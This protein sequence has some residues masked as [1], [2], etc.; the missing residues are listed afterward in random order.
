MNNV[1]RNSLPGYSVDF[2]VYSDS[3]DSSITEPPGANNWPEQYETNE[4]FSLKQNCHTGKINDLIV[5]GKKLKN[6]INCLIIQN[7]EKSERL[8]KLEAKIKFLERGQSSIMK[9]VTS[10]FKDWRGRVEKLEQAVNSPIHLN[11]S[12]SKKK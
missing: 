10:K 7:D 4:K 1:N 11:R 3:D 6:K 5:N 9:S 12:N 2:S 8:D